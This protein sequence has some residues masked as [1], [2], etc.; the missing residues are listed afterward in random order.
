MM[1]WTTV[2]VLLSGVRLLATGVGTLLVSESA[3]AVLG[4]TGLLGMAC[5]IVGTLTGSL[6]VSVGALACAI[7]RPLSRYHP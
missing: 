5:Y 6:L 4:P 1:Q 2:Q 3:G 7:A